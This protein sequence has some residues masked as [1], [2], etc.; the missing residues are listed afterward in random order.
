MPR[1]RLLRLRH[2]AAAMLCRA[3]FFAMPLIWLLRCRMLMPLIAF[4]CARYAMFRQF[5]A[6]IRYGCHGAFYMR[7][8]DACC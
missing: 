5:Y 6:M 2:A 4:S 3:R 8:A 1:A 7:A